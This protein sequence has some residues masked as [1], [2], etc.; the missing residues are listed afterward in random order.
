MRA[1]KNLLITLCCVI[2]ISPTLFAQHSGGK[3]TPATKTTQLIP[4]TSD[5]TAGQKVKFRAVTRDSSGT[6]T[7]APATAWFV[8]PF[9]LAGV[10]QKGTVSF[11][12]PGEVVVGA[13]VAGRSTFVRVVVKPAPVARIGIEPMKSAVVVGIIAKLTAV[14]RTA[15]G[16]T[17]SDLAVNWTSSN[18][19]VATIDAAG[20]VTGIAPGQVK[21]T[22]T[23]G[24][25]SGTINVTVVKGNLS[26]LSID[27]RST[28]GRTGDVVHFNVR[29]RSGPTDNYAVRWTVN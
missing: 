4:E 3:S 9:D 5:I 29:A 12:N 22:A 11:F 8:A 25:G 14:A 24:S 26:G 19:D 13:I 28:N 16:N 10:D 17:R 2:T 6:T 21:L 23:A 18:P 1:L 15:A 7:P 27:P 20:V